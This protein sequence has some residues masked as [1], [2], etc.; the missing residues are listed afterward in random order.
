MNASPGPNQRESAVRNAGPAGGADAEFSPDGPHADP[1]TSFKVARSSSLLP[2]ESFRAGIRRIIRS[3]LAKVE[4]KLKRLSTAP[5]DTVHNVRKRLKRVRAILCGVRGDLGKSRYQRENGRLRE[6][7]RQL[8]GVRNAKVLVATF[9]AIREKTGNHLAAELIAQIEQRLVVERRRARDDLAAHAQVL[10][11]A[12]R[13]IHKT[14]A[15]VKRWPIKRRKMSALRDGLKES[16]NSATRA[17]ETAE[18][19]PTIENL[20][21]WRKRAKC[22]F[23]QLELVAG[24]AGSELQMLL[25][26]L[27]DLTQLLGADHDLAILRNEVVACTAEQPVRGSES[28]VQ[29]IDHDRAALQRDFFSAAPPF[30]RGELED[31]VYQLRHWMK[32]AGRQ[33]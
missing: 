19:E 12:R 22:L 3:Q 1:C 25:G 17:I 13:E 15:G 26:R 31:A 14:R 5:D 8:A 23:H 9:A 18:R 33:V 6:V 21:E 27:N 11:S 29:L 2:D 10:E 32:R 30:F 24:L 20:H 4:R 16:F 7:G 28:L